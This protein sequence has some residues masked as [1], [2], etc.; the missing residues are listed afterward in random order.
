MSHLAEINVIL[1]AFVK[2]YD[3]EDHHKNL[4]PFIMFFSCSKV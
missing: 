1:N 3:I 2:A 4:K